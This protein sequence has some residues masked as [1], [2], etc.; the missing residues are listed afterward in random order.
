MRGGNCPCV[1]VCTGARY[2]GYCGGGGGGVCAVATVR[3]L[4]CVCT[5]ARYLGYCGGGGG[6]GVCARAV[7]T[8]S[9]LM[10]VQVR[11]ILDI[12]AQCEEAGLT[13]AEET[14]CKLPSGISK[15][16]RVVFM[17]TLDSPLITEL[18]PMGTVDNYGSSHGWLGKLGNSSTVLRSSDFGGR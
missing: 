4:V 10:C 14:K 18:F 8:N 9:A 11:G 1:S 3:A 15:Q 17:S 16:Y 5:G 13:T 6:G 2:L 12:A 7:A